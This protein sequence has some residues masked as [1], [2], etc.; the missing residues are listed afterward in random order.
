MVG[1]GSEAEGELELVPLPPQDIITENVKIK[2]R[3]F[4]SPLHKAPY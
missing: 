4:I 3:Y 2:K 1:A